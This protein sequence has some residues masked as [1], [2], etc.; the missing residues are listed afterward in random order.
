MSQKIAAKMVKAMAT[1]DAVEKKGRNT[2][3][4]YNFVRAAD[5]ANEV[6]KALKDAGIAFAY[7]VEQERFWDS[8]TKNGGLQFYCSLKVRGTFIDSESGESVECS[9][10][11]WGADTGDKAPYKAMTGALK[12]MLRMPFLIPDESDP[13]ESEPEPAT[14]PEVVR[15]SKQADPQTIEEEVEYLNASDFAALCSVAKEHG[16]DKDG[17]KEA[18]A[19]VGAKSTA[20]IPATETARLM[21]WAR[22]EGDL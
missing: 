12:Y 4:N 22:K 7:N 14:R 5:V 16:W 8:P 9:T 13:E 21:A 18:I 19:K 10:I 17:I 2:M 15:K 20:K 3:Q 1:I 6:R 11:G